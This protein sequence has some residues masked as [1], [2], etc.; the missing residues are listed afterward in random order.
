MS[1]VGF[2][3]LGNMGRPM[4]SNLCRKGSKLIVFDVKQDPVRTLEGLGARAAADVA[5]I[6]SEC[7][8]VFTMLPASADVE[9]VVTGPSGLLAGLRRGAM[10]VDMSTIDPQVT[11][12]LAAAAA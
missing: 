4:A 11:D 7:D 3:G 12:R 8:I 5:T 9:T 10:I 2:I 1:M 6:A